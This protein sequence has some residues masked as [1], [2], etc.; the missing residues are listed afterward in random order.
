MLTAHSLHCAA[1]TVST[2]HIWPAHSIGLMG[3]RLSMSSGPL[4]FRLAGGLLESRPVRERGETVC[5]LW[6]P[7]RPALLFQWPSG[8][9]ENNS[10]T[11]TITI[12]SSPHSSS[13]FCAS[14]SQSIGRPRASQRQA[15]SPQPPAD[16]HRAAIRLPRGPERPLGGRRG[17]SAGEPLPWALAR[18]PLGNICSH[19]SAHAGDHLRRHFRPSW[20]SQFLRKKK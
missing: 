9:R 1:H 10:D 3:A 4:S 19:Y 13:P 16:T 17:Q 14:I 20:L 11:T 15:S 18:R 8:D 12:T 7:W 6:R 2:E 5:G